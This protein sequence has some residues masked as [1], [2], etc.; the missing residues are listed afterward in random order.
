MRTTILNQ[1]IPR[2]LQALSVG[3]HKTKNLVQKDFNLGVKIPI[4][5][6]TL[7]HGGFMA[8]EA[9]TFFIKRTLIINVYALVFTVVS[10]APPTEV[11]RTSG[12]AESGK[13]NRSSG[14]EQENTVANVVENSK[15]SSEAVI[16]TNGIE[17]SVEV[18][19]ELRSELLAADLDPLTAGEIV[20]SAK[21]YASTQASQLIL[22]TNEQQ[23]LSLTES[24]NP[25]ETKSR[26]SLRMQ[27]AVE[28]IFAG[29][30]EHIG[31][32]KFTD[33]NDLDLR[34][35]VAKLAL[36]SGLKSI[37]NRLQSSKGSLSLKS[38]YVK[39][40]IDSTVE[41]GFKAEEL[42][43]AT[44]LLFVAVVEASSNQED[45]D[46]A[47]E[48][49]G[50]VFEEAAMKLES[51]L[52]AEVQIEELMK[53]STRKSVYASQKKSVLEDWGYVLT[54]NIV[55]IFVKASLNWENETNKEQSVKAITLG[56][57]QGIGS[58]EAQDERMEGKV[59]QLSNTLVDIIAESEL[60]ADGQES[61]VVLVRD[62]MIAGIE[63]SEKETE[64]IASMV[65]EGVGT[66]VGRL[67]S[68]KFDA[69]K[70]SSLASDMVSKTV[71][72]ANTSVAIREASSES[73][74][75]FLGDVIEGVFGK[76]S[77]NGKAEDAAKTGNTLDKMSRAA[78]D[79]FAEITDK[80][81]EMVAYTSLIGD[82]AVPAVTNCEETAWEDTKTL[83]GYLLKG[84]TAS[85]RSMTKKGKMKKSDSDESLVGIASK[86]IGKVSSFC[87]ME[88]VEDIAIEL[89]AGTVKGA[90]EVDSKAD[91]MG[92]RETVNQNIMSKMAEIEI[93]VEDEDEI[94]T[95]SV[96][97]DFEGKLNYDTAKVMEEEIEPNTDGRVDSFESCEVYTAK[98]PAVF[99]SEF[100]DARSEERSIMCLRAEQCP[101]SRVLSNDLTIKFADY[102]ADKCEIIAEKVM[103]ESPR[104]LTVSNSAV[105]DQDTAEVEVEETRLDTPENL[106]KSWS[107]WKG[108]RITFDAVKKA[109]W[110]VLKIK[111]SSNKKYFKIK[112]G[113]EPYCKLPTTK[114]KKGTEYKVKIQAFSD[115]I[116]KSKSS[117]SIKFEY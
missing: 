26:F 56:A 14:E 66:L 53:K 50:V 23:G 36:Q 37:N 2:L 78:L 112:C 105:V 67:P 40:S 8:L 70:V 71:E 21:S 47:V 84:V 96:D 38:N 27:W 57:I 111:K 117:E 19:E 52:P 102:G 116:K 15:A 110:Y 1:M 13:V 34:S 30:A 55:K 81:S 106:K 49:I 31:S 99:Y 35:L 5:E 103:V 29:V 61:M 76:L 41:K 58:F 43:E 10:C 92:V 108:H 107:F 64:Q 77:K 104:V 7:K 95:H 85:I 39:D 60:D 63:N 89:A 20:E 16:A 73:K 79:S 87:D 94:E 28:K 86:A 48:E 3:K 17:L 115:S 51:V 33:K 97:G 72:M 90:S 65:K 6:V 68:L 44:S 80:Q 75:S 83:A 101:S 24:S 9:Y 88:K 12:K 18:A 11:L 82:R 46:K 100:D 93:E 74:M 4:E 45:G 113:S 98:D 91:M 54:K 62:G 59:N 25:S 109:D 42:D 32:E 69:E 114:M 22:I